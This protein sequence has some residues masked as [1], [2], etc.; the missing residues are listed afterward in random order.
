MEKDLDP[1]ALALLGLVRRHTHGG[2]EAPATDSASF[3][4]AYDV[5][6]SA[7]LIQHSADRKIWVITDAGERLLRE[8]YDE[9]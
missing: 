1:E 4:A 8:R 3:A 7:D 6:I 5:L 2:P 9:R